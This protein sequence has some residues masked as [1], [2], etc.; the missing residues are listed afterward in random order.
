[1]RQLAE[2][3]SKLNQDELFKCLNDLKLPS[4]R[5]IILFNV[6]TNQH[7]LTFHEVLDIHLYVAKE[8]FLSEFELHGIKEHLYSKSDLYE[9]DPAKNGQNLIKHG[10][11]FDEVVSYS[12]KFGTLSVACPD[13]NDKERLILFSD[14]SASRSG[15][16][17]SLPIEKVANE[18]EMYVMSVCQL[19]SLKFRFISSRVMSRKRYIKTLNNALKNIYLNEPEKKNALVERCFLWFPRS[20]V[21]TSLD[22][23]CGQLY[24]AGAPT[25]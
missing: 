22:R 20:S 3:I 25:R 6:L 15:C 24:G 9:Y 17:L 21:V 13:E 8:L 2:V 16:K 1:M 5:K 19:K 14:I 12:N 10:I 23:S 11:S 18:E 7:N 4:D